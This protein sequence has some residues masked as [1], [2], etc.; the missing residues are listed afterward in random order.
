MEIQDLKSP[1]TIEFV[2]KLSKLNGL[3]REALSQHTPHFNGEKYM[4]NVD[5]C[6]FLHISQRTLQD[7]RDTGKIGYI[8][9]SGKILYKESDILKLLEENYVPAQ[10]H[11]WPY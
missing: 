6:K 11:K 5:I 4:T 9:I 10:N 1:G 8:Q 7:Y 3:I 2:N